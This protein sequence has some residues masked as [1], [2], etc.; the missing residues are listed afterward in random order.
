MWVDAIAKE[1]TNVWVV[2]NILEDG[3]Q[4]LMQYQFVKC[5]MIFDVKMEDTFCMA[6]FVRGEHMV[7]VPCTIT[8]ASVVSVK[9]C[10]L[11]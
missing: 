3:R 5:H 2:F 1:I 4:G 10:I 7:D 8:Y 6:R 11:Q 9:L